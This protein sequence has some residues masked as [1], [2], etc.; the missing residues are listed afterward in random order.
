MVQ[1]NWPS[2]LVIIALVFAALFIYDKKSIAS[3]HANE[4]MIVALGDKQIWQLKSGQVRWCMIG[5]GTEELGKVQV[6]DPIQWDSSNGTYKSNKNPLFEDRILQFQ[7]VACSAWSTDKPTI[8][9]Q[10]DFK[11]YNKK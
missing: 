5:M 2:G 1:L 4:Q 7:N 6:N 10:K 9:G 8:F 3:K 11:G